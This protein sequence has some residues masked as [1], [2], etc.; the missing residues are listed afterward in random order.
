MRLRDYPGDDALRT[1]A[2]ESPYRFLVYQIGEKS[3]RSGSGSWVGRAAFLRSLGWGLAVTYIPRANYGV[4]SATGRLTALSRS[5]GAADGFQAV[6]QCRWDG[7]PTGTI[8][9]IDALALPGRENWLDYYKGWIA[10]VLD[11]GTVRPGTRC[12]DKDAPII[13]AAARAAFDERGRGAE[14]SSWWILVTDFGPSAPDSR[15]CLPPLVNIGDHLDEERRAD[16][17]QSDRSIT[18]E[19]FGGVSLALS[20][21]WASAPDPSCGS[22][23]SDPATY[24]AALRPGLAAS[25]MSIPTSAAVTDARALIEACLSAL[26]LVQPGGAPPFPD[27]IGMVEVEVTEHEG[28]TKARIRIAGRDGSG[29][30]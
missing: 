11:G 30:G 8:C 13:A 25:T 19:S 14:A 27:G 3:E 28:T 23:A 4:F 1:W 21:C 15:Q 17:W 6:A 16:V 22:S 26:A 10:A 18:R 20:R 29:T 2:R 24:A 9:Y 5:A 12:A 7:L